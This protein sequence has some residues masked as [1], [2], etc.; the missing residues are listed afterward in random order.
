ML[1]TTVTTTLFTETDLIHL[2]DQGTLGR[3]QTLEVFIVHV[4]IDV[5]KLFKQPFEIRNKV[6]DIILKGPN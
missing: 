2:I 4:F 6:V 1:L 3:D 5:G